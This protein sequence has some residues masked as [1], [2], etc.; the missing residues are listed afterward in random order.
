M[1]FLEKLTGNN[2]SDAE[3]ADSAKKTILLA[4][5]NRV[6]INIR[7]L[8]DLAQQKFASEPQSLEMVNEIKKDLERLEEEE[9]EITGNTEEERGLVKEKITALEEL[10]QK[11]RTMIDES[12]D[13]DN[14]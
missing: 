5:I 14:N 11:L 4:E 13:E 10:H 9:R 1:S 8:L 7:S 6:A 2:G 12:E 3:A